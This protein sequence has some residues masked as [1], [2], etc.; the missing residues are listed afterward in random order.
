[1]TITINNHEFNLLAIKLGLINEDNKKGSKEIITLIKN[2]LNNTNENVT[3]SEPIFIDQP[4][5]IV[6]FVQRCF[7]SILQKYRYRQLLLSIGSQHQFIIQHAYKIFKCSCDVMKDSGPYCGE[8]HYQTA[9]IKELG[10][11]YKEVL[12]EKAE[13][14]YY[15][16]SN[17]DITEID[18]GKY[19]RHDVTIKDIESKQPT[20]LE[21]KATKDLKEDN[22][23]QISNYIKNARRN[24]QQFDKDIPFNKFG[25][26]INFSTSDKVTLVL[27]KEG[28]R[29]KD[30]KIYTWQ[31]EI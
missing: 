22:Y 1:M 29:E 28:R 17:G 14:C 30:I 10:L 18:N 23:V 26:L 21:L 5:D 3:I 27:T 19:E 4:D 24:I 7:K 20:I 16:M 12:Q 31:K 25:M 2:N 8:K 11:I 6:R 15:K 9:L 13:T